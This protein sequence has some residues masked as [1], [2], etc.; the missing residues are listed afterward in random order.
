MLDVA[1]VARTREVGADELRVVDPD[2]ATLRNVN[3]P[4]EYLEALRQAGLSS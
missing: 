2:L 1:D 3:T 4:E